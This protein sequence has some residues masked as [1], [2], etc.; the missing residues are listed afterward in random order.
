[1]DSG[2]KCDG[3]PLLDGSRDQRII[4]LTVAGDERALRRLSEAA[5]T[6]LAA[7][8]K[9]AKTLGLTPRLVKNCRLAGTRPSMRECLRCDISFLSISRQNRMC[10]RC[11]RC[12]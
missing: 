7:V 12:G 5:G 2:S 6:N 9:R 11:A 3:R 4:D 10:S 1:M 8:R